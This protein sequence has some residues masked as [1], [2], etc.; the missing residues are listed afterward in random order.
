M[1]PS[2]VP[3]GAAGTTRREF[4]VHSAILSG[5]AATS[6]LV[7]PRSV[8][9][10]GSDALRIGLIGCGGRGAGAVASALSV[11][12]GAKL[13]AVSDAFKDR[14]ENACAQ[15]KKKSPDQVAVNHDHLFDDFNGY[16][17]MLESGV[18]VA[19][20]A[21][22]PHF[23]PMHAE[24]CVEAGVHTFLEKPMA[25]D[26]SGVRRIL[27]AGQK[28]REKNLS[29]VS[30]FE[31]RYS[32]AA[33]Q[34][35]RRVHDGAIGRIVSMEMTYNTGFLWHRGREPNWTEMQFQMRNWYYF[36][37]LSGDHL[38]EQHVHLADFTNWIMHEEPPLHAWG[39]GGR[40][41]RTDPK[42]GDIFDHHAVV[43]EYAG[44]ARLYAFTRQQAN[45][46]NE[47]SK[48][49]QGTKG[50]LQSGLGG[51]GKYVITGE[52]EW[53]APSEAGHPELTTFREMFEGIRAGKPI[54]DS[55][56][57]AGSTMLAIL[58]RMATHSGQKITWDEAFKSDH[59][60]APASYAWDA[61]PP[62]LPGKDGRYPEPIPGETKVL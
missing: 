49:V 28:A 26:S 32:E 8:H 14:A 55:R 40:Q 46:Y 9:A 18:D 41:V 35:V 5:A 2:N 15:L 45:A 6:G 43:Y 59:V 52:Q 37:W 20:L 42:W 47:V 44:G 56:A 21:E 48:L 60:L 50:S 13:V 4:L 10:A 29:F 39:Y 12:P 17:R 23:R 16:L 1:K 53:T 19:I 30:G 27:A 25:V 24:A 11:D 57:M 61:D 33:R 62:V 54:N 58:G 7:S 36:T 22:P 31:T 38:V 3:V 34:A 51:W